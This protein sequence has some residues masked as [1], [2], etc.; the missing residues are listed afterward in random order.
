MIELKPCPFCGNNV[1]YNINMDME[2]DGI[3]CGHCKM[4]VRFTRVKPAQKGETFGD[5]QNR[6]AD[7]WNRRE[8]AKE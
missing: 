3:W 7:C 8:G 2:P 1:R 5:V 4:I 6:I